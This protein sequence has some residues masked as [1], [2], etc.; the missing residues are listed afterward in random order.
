MRAIQLHP[1]FGVEHLGVVQIEKPEVGP[2]Q[3][4]L[5]MTAASLNYRD[6]LMVRGHYNPKQ[7]LPLVPCSDG[8]GW[9]EAVGEGVDPSWMGQ[10]VCPTFAESWHGGDF[11]STVLQSTRG[12][13]LPGT[14]QEWMCVPAD[15]VVIPPSHLTDEEAACLPCAGV[16]AYRALVELGG[17]TA[18]Q[19]VLLQGTGGVSLM[20]L[21]IAK[22]MGAVVAMTSSQDDRISRA[23]EWGADVGFNYRTGPNWGKEAKAWTGG[24][25]FDHIVEVGGAGTLEQSLRAI[26]GGGTI[27]VI[28]VLSGVKTE[29][30]LT[31]VLM[32]Q[33]RMQGI[34]VGSQTT[35]EGLNRLFTAH[36]LRPPI[37]CVFELEQIQA[38][39]A[40][41]AAGRHMGKV[42][43][44]ISDGSV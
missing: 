19:R 5:R 42:V 9:V 1:S 29:L 25:G 18:G 16:T 39:F 3:L 20:A 4:L 35:F 12:G 40:H 7:P 28:G 27:H 34:F 14:L 2:G 32:H 13:P 23:M 36:Q 30:L 26:A 21:R 22:A 38:A 41:L 6:L 31:R 44:H 15:A 43:I 24:H 10:R 8:V 17:L 11:N 37:D 33:V